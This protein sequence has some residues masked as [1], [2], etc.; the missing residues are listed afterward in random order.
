MGT[1]Q[2]VEELVKTLSPAERS[3]MLR[4]VGRDVPAG[5]PGIEKTP[6]VCG[7]SACIIRTRIPVWLLVESKNLGSTD[8]ELLDAHPTLRK[9]DL[10]CAWEYAE[11]YPLEIEHEIFENSEEEMR[12]LDALE[13]ESQ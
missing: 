3:H 8:D 2:Q 10:A 4:F 7:G 5:F 6:G 11:A 13:A 1:L 9:Q 12:R